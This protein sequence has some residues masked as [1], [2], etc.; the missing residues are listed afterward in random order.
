MWNRKSVGEGLGKM[1]ELEFYFSIV[2]YGWVS[3]GKI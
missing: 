3:I 2:I 1:V